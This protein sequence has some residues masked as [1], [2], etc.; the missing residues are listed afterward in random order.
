MLDISVVLAGATGDL[1]LRIARALHADGTPT[2][3]LVRPDAAAAAVRAL[4]AMGHEIFRTDLVDPAEIARACVGA[5]C[6]VSALSGLRPVIVGAQRRLLDGTVAAGVP[7]FIPSDFSIDFTRLPEGSNRNLD[8]RREFGRRLDAA[9]IRA[10]TI[11]NGAFADMLGGQMP[12][13]IGKIHRVV[14]WGDADTKMDFTTKDDTAA[15][16]ARAAADPDTPRYLH[17]AGTKASAREL[18]ADAEA[19]TGGQFKLLRAGSLGMLAGLIKLTRR[20]APQPEAIYSPWQGMQYLHNMM[21][22]SAKAPKLDNDRYPDLAWTS[23]RQVLAKLR[24]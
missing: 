1:G 18:V 6:V 7:R 21:S 15:F 14:Y 22:G 9:P 5:S 2:R 8:L 23:T 20:L 24:D 4:Q 13:V 11:F 17:V 16:T 12:I 10:T 3:A 19:A